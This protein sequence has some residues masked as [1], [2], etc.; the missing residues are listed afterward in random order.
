MDGDVPVCGPYLLP[1]FPLLLSLDA[2]EGAPHE[3]R[4]RY[5]AETDLTMSVCVCVCDP[6]LCEESNNRRGEVTLC[7]RGRRGS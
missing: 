7:V 6:C 1:S 2:S 3:R 5:F 4:K